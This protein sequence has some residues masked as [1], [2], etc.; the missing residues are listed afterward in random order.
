MALD[1]KA[2]KDI[3]EKDLQ[4]LIANQVPEDK[5]IDYKQTL[6]LEKP[7][8]KKEVLK[9]ISAF[10]NTIGGHIIYGMKEK[11]GIPVEL[12]GMAVDDPDQI[13]QRIDNVIRDCVDPRIYGID[14]QPVPL[15][16]GNFSIVVRIPRSFN[17][18]HM[19]TIGGHRQF[20]ARTSSGTIPLSV[21]ELRQLFLLSDTTS[22]RLRDFRAERL[23]LLLTDYAPASLIPGLKIVLHIVPFDSLVHQ[24]SYDLSQIATNQAPIPHIKWASRFPQRCYNFEGYLSYNITHVDNLRKAYTYTQIFR[25]GIIEAVYVPGYGSSQ[26]DDYPS[27]L[28]LDYEKYIT[29]FV[30]EIFLIYSI[31][32]ISPPVFSLLTLLE[33]KGYILTDN[34]RFATVEGSPFDRDRLVLPEVMISEFESDV[35]QKMRGS[36]DIVRNA[37]SLEPKL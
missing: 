30:K 3:T 28:E 18:P 2:L 33:C 4:N 5:T 12:S 27:L 25:S 9:D 1:N 14:I 17:P 23:S 31:M 37:A 16:N 15:H 22:E 35:M 32:G 19:V 34:V 20:Y 29:N 21:Q 10:A 36:F 6:H 8:D 13:K 7:S 11:K 26:S 24:K